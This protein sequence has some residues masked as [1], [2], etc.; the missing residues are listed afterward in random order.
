VSFGD[1]GGVVQHRGVEGGEGGQSIEEEDGRRLSSLEEHV[2]A[3]VA[4]LRS[5]SDE[6]RGSR[7]SSTNWT[8]VLGRSELGAERKGATGRPWRHL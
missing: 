3:G 2:T 8:G 6:G 7:C 4:A 5:N 1:G